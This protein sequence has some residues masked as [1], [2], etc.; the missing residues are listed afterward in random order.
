MEDTLPDHREMQGA[1]DTDTV[2]PTQLQA[3]YANE[4]TQT[5]EDPTARH[6]DDDPSEEA[7]PTNDRIDEPP[8]NES[9]R[10]NTR[11][12][13]SG[14]HSEAS[15]P[16]KSQTLIS[17]LATAIKNG[18]VDE[19]KKLLDADGAK[20][21]VF[22]SP[23][24][25]EGVTP[26][27]IAAIH[28]RGQI[29]ELLLDTGA[30]MDS[31]DSNDWWTALHYA[32]RFDRVTIARLLLEQG[33]SKDSVNY[34][35]G[36]PLSIAAQKGHLAMTELLLDYGS[37]VDEPDDDRMPPLHHA[38]ANGHYE[39]VELLLKYDADVQ[40]DDY[41]GRNALHH[42]CEQES[43]RF[44]R[45]L[46]GNGADDPDILNKS[47]KHGCTPLQYATYGD[48][49]STVD[50]LLAQRNIDLKHRDYDEDTALSE[51]AY[52]KNYTI[53]MKILSHETYMPLNP[54]RSRA[55]SAKKFEGERIS[56][57]LIDCLEKD[58]NN[59]SSDLEAIMF[60]A[61]VNGNTDLVRDCLGRNESLSSWKQYNATWIHMAAKYGH[62]DLIEK[63]IGKGL[64]VDDVA[65]GGI[66]VLH[67]AVESGNLPAVQT[68]SYQSLKSRVSS[69]YETQPKSVEMRALH[70][71]QKFIQANDQQEKES[72]FSLA[73]RGKRKHIEDFFWETLTTILRLVRGAKP[74]F[75][76][77]REHAQDGQRLLAV[78]A[79][80]DRP[81]QEDNLKYLLTTMFKHG[82]DA[83]EESATALQ[84]AVYHLQ[85]VP[86]WWLLS[87]G[88]HL[89]TKEIKRALEI[90]KKRDTKSKSSNIIDQLLHNPPP[91]I[92]HSANPFDDDQ[93]EWQNVA[94]EDVNVL[95]RYG[96]I[97]DFYRTENKK[98]QIDFQ[99]KQ[100]ILRSIIYTQ[101][102]SAI[103]SQAK[104]ENYRDLS[105]L[106]RAMKDEH[107]KSEPSPPTQAEAQSVKA[108]NTA[109]ST[110]DK[111]GS[112]P[113]FRWIHVPAN[114]MNLVKDLVTRLSSDMQKTNKQ[115]RS[116]VSFIDRSWTKMDAGGRRRFMKPQCLRHVEK[117]NAGKTAPPQ[118]PDTKPKLEEK[119]KHD[120]SKAEQKK[121]SNEP[122]EN[123][124]PTP[125]PDAN[126]SGAEKK[127]TRSATKPTDNMKTEAQPRGSIAL[128]M[129]FLS[130]LNRDTP[131][132]NKDAA[133]GDFS[134][135]KDEKKE[136]NEDA[137]SKEKPVGDF[138]FLKK[139]FVRKWDEE[140]AHSRMTLDQFYYATV[141]DTKDRDNDQVLSRYLQMQKIKVKYAKDPER[142][143]QEIRKLRANEGKGNE[144]ET[145]LTVDQLWLWVID[146]ST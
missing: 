46:L 97:F 51:A 52:R 7:R 16:G 115:H 134:E 31:E 118:S 87:N 65:D 95:D 88:G 112:N 60:W 12:E 122:R 72:P 135:T 13:R 69:E 55:F 56:K 120:D 132:L 30:D 96:T 100:E 105:V 84:W 18:Y 77:S 33:A 76:V 136:S 90:L 64:S 127:K 109:S 15:S 23:R 78:A 110:K 32:A 70:L 74:S 66:T 113:A 73:V 108:Q 131:S 139:S 80:L 82:D 58:E 39:I 79:Q 128:Y 146:E 145:I 129:P 101:G 8:I 47:D 119:G 36:T 62:P 89:R 116:L 34:G 99:Y 17:E 61:V 41:Y 92:D 57:V 104:Q 45:L 54:V 2:S 20:S 144:K 25:D 71:I 38:I 53:M 59:S 48:R 19:V 124:N 91:V 93:V 49:E 6:D 4:E 83:P 86:V 111:K 9:D 106:E 40:Q 14:S 50:L 44:T 114:D 138:D 125:Y 137:G 126:I 29:A 11:T 98:G 130:I 28:G 27:M 141:P 75:W 1:T 5:V 26:L 3:T 43:S 121:E 107:C 102:P 37:R 94:P 22:P 140:I 63:L 42:A 21:I 143:D 10:H 133:T 68:V 123:D 142:M 67:F 117:H 35:G 24:T 103:M 81:G 85:P